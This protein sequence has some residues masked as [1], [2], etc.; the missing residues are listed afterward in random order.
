MDRFAFIQPG[1]GVLAP[2]WPHGLGSVEVTQG[3]DGVIHDL[4]PNPRHLK[5]G[6]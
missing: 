4:V 2:L 6:L 3:L 5:I 1:G